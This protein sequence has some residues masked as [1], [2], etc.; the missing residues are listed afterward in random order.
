MIA[1]AITKAFWSSCESPHSQFSE[2]TP[3]NIDSSMLA[4]RYLYQHLVII[5]QAKTVSENLYPSIWLPKWKLYNFLLQNTSSFGVI[6]NFLA[7]V[8]RKDDTIALYTDLEH[9]ML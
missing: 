9:D 3:A 7:H 5:L 4:Q 6:A 8:G 2:Y 1:I